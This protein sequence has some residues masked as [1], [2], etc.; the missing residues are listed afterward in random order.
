MATKTGKIKSTNRQGTGATQTRS[1][2]LTT[3]P[4]PPGAEI[5]FT[6]DED[7]YDDAVAAGSRQV[8]VTYT[9]NPAGPPETCSGL[10][11]VN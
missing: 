5:V 6:C 2:T 9:P 10:K 1:F 8:E 3:D 4:N 11:I 7:Y